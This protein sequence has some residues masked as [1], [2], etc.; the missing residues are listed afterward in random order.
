MKQ[1]LSLFIIVTS[2]IGSPDCCSSQGI[3]TDNAS[4]HYKSMIYRFYDLLGSRDVVYIDEATEIFGKHILETE[5]LIFKEY[6]SEDSL[7]L[8]EFESSIYSIGNVTESLLF[9][10][11]KKKK[12]TFTFGLS[13]ESV[14]EII[15]QAKV[16]YDL[17][18]AFVLVILYFPEDQPIYFA[19]NKDMNETPSITIFLPNGNWMYSILDL[20]EVYTYQ[21][22]VLG[23]IYDMDGYTNLRDGLSAQNRIIRKIFDGQLFFYWPTNQSDWWKVKTL[24]TC[25]VGYM[26]KSRIMP[27]NILVEGTISTDLQRQVEMA[28]GYDRS[29]R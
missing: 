18:R 11:F 16:V 20:P 15:K 17:N 10:M 13:R 27:F 4:D 5:I 9:N 6:Y 7:K 26:H 12:E 1:L 2:V 28:Y 21:L 19:V 22:N 8:D 14:F 3:N 25:E 29:C 24:D 23:Q